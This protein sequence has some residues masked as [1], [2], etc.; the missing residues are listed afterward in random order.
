[1]GN[2]NKIKLIAADGIQVV[3]DLG[4]VVVWVGLARVDASESRAGAWA[5]RINEAK[6]PVAFDNDCIGGITFVFNEVNAIVYAVCIR[7]S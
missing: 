5:H 3:G 4:A 6:M 1:M 7:C 2:Y